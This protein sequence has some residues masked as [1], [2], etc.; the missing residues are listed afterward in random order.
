MDIWGNCNPSEECNPRSHSEH[1]DEHSDEHDHDHDHNHSLSIE[2]TALD[3][4]IMLP[5]VSESPYEFLQYT[6]RI[7]TPK[8]KIFLYDGKQVGILYHHRHQTIIFHKFKSISNNYLW[9]IYLIKL[10]KK[11]FYLI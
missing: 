1:S 6:K 2:I 4:I 11:I 3:E 8:N 7:D 9:I 5:D 10:L